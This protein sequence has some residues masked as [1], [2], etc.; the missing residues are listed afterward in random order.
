MYAGDA[1]AADA[2][3]VKKGEYLARAGD[4]IACHT[5]PGGKPFA[6]GLMMET[7]VGGISTP[8][9]TPDQKT[10]IGTWTDDQFF[11]AMHEGIGQHGEYLYPAF[12][13]PWYTNVHARRRPGDQGLSVFA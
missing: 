8:N 9:I 10:G 6:G 12:P 3:L 4:C 11:R 2:D 5:A 1:G 13:F 7:P